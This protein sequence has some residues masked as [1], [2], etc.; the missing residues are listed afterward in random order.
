MFGL[1][2]LGNNSA[3]PAYDRHPTSQAVT[4]NEQVF[5][6][7]CGEGTQM[8]LTRYKVRRSRINYIFISHLHGD[9]YFGLIGLLTSMGLLGRENDLHLFAPAPL[10]HIIQLQLNAADTKL[11]YTLRFHALTEDAIIADTDK[12]SIECFKVFHRIECYGFIIREK[13]RLR[14]LDRNKAIEQDIPASYFE[15]LKDGEDY[16]KPDGTVVKNESVTNP[17]V[18]GKSYAFAADTMYKESIA[19]KVKDVTLLYH[20]ATYLKIHS[21]RATDRFHSTAEQAAMIAKS[22]GVQ[23]LVLGH[24]SSKYEKLDEFLTEARE[25]FSNTDLALEGVTYLL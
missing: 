8:Q 10:E 24:F 22:A 19:E 14:K 20:E 15:K 21:E 17:N 25:I 7:D 6:L 4:L 13:K 9:H 11:P 16:I 2:I 23:K 1:T 18:P 12:F 5:L 3:I